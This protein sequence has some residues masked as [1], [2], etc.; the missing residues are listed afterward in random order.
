MRPRGG[1]SSRRRH[2]GAG[3]DLVLEVAL[4]YV[5]MYVIFIIIVI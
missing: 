3:E 1:K 5:Y 4:G 2:R